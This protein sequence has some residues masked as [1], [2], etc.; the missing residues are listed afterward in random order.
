MEVKVKEGYKQTELG[1]IPED[2]RACEFKDVITGFSSGMTPY[3][4]RPEY[5]KGDIRWITSGELNYNIIT[6]TEEKITKEAVIKTNLKILSKGTFLMAI[7]GLE[8]EGTRGSCGIVGVEATTNQSCMALYPISGEITTDYLYHFYV[9]YGNE[10]AFKYCQGTK[11]Q[12]Y[13]GR[14]AKILPINLPSTVTEQTT[15][16]TALSDASV[17]IQSLEKFIAKKHAIKQGVMQELLKPKAGWVVRKLGEVCNYQNGTS[18]EK[19][20]NHNDGLKVISIGNYSPHGK[21][22]DTN[23][24]IS[25]EYLSNIGSFILNKNDLT[26]ILNDKTSIGTIIGRVLLIGADNA[27]AFN[28]RTMRLSPKLGSN[29]LFLYHLINSSLIHSRLVALAKPGTQIYVNTNDIVDFELS[30]PKLEEQIRIAT[31]LSDMDAEIAALKTKLAK[32]QQVKQG[33]MQ[34]LL[35]GRI[36]LI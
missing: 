6:D 18:L 36:R 10:L 8:A 30:V 27:F 25:T 28:Q 34:N 35:N 16:A 19:Y 1:V 23:T 7:T 4:G 3:R 12:S 13:T 32:Y 17:L 20:F 29:P 24:F 15:I 21:F 14:I 5:Y 26:M 22:I 2:W 33:M 11:Q 31:I 9:H